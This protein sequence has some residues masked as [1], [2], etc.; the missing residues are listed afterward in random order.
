M[1]FYQMLSQQAKLIKEKVGTY[2]KAGK[3]CNA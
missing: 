1:R 3:T 2:M